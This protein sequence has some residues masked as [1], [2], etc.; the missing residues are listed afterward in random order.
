ML[1]GKIPDSTIFRRMDQ[2]PGA[3][4]IPGVIV[5]RIDAPI[6]FPNASYLKER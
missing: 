3:H 6:L 4:S 5:L 2:Y 1:L